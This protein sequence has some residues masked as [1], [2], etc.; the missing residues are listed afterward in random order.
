MNWSKITLGASGK[1]FTQ[2]LYAFL[3]SG[4]L[5]PIEFPT[6]RVGNLLVVSGQISTVEDQST[7][8]LGR[9]A[10]T[11]RF[12]V[13][14][15]NAKITLF[16]SSGESYLYHQDSTILGRYT[17][18]GIT[19]V[20]GKTYYIRITLDTDEVYESTPE[21][22]PE[23]P[24]EISTY[25]E[26]N[27]E[28][29]TDFEGI[30]SQRPFVKLYG[31]S[32]L[33]TSEPSYLKWNVEE[34]FLLTP[35][36]FADPFGSVP[37]ACFIVQNADPQ[38]IP[39]FNGDDIS[40]Q[41]IEIFLA[42]RLVDYSFYERHYFTTYQSAITK[43]SFEYWTKVNALANQ[44]GSIFD[45]PPAQIK[46]NIFNVNAADEE[47]L[48]YFQASNQVFH[49]FFILASDLDVPILADK[50]TYD[51]SRM[52][53]PYRCLDCLSVRNSSLTAPSWF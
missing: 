9:T 46:G 25:Y 28:E 21:K 35:T 26:T 14:V 51:P 44:V 29:Y 52:Q 12:P 11:E 37:P 43:E 38:G 3:F 40:A 4:C 49:R 36:D 30:I 7:I 17:L 13:P 31:N 47:V 24:G 32:V 10:D 1:I 45:T 8:E 19:G 33:P 50:C 27:W 41:S 15:T 18:T 34:T 2:L 53:Y 23:S 6:E 42:S 22:M 5:T 20:S 48:G 39:L 16:V